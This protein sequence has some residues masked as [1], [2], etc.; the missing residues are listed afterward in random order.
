M[1]FKKLALASAIAAMPMSAFALDEITDEALSD[2]SGQDGIS[3]SL[4]IGTGGILTDVFLHDTDGISVNGSGTGSFGTGYSFDGAIVIDNLRLAGGALTTIV[5]GIDAGASAT[6]VGAPILNIN[7][8]LPAALTIN[9]GALM[10]ANSQRDS[11]A[12]SIDGLSATIMN[13]MSIVLGG[14]ALNIQLGNEQQAGTLAGSDMAVLSASVASGIVIGGFRLSDATTGA[15]G[16]GA[17]TITILDA[18]STTTLT[19]AVDVNVVNTGL[20]IGLGQVGS[21][22]GVDIRILRQ[23]LG[24]DTNAA[25]GDVSIVG[26]NMNGSIITINGK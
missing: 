14:T 26:L 17:S 11:S 13:N 23:Y 24:T 21:N 6:S 1:N 19:L 4:I 20:Q 9:T 5:I 3:A 25:I 22:N 12:W 18:G 16:I 10:V 15:G 7:V 2:M 8:G